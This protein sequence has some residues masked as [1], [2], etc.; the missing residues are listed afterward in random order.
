MESLSHA[1]YVE[2]AR[3]NKRPSIRPES[4]PIHKPLKQ[5]PVTHIGLGRRVGAGLDQQRNA[6]RVTVESGANQRRISVLS[7]QPPQTDH[8]ETKNMHT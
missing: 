3:K 1:H 5:R 8:K 7:V 2:V 6:L 4:E